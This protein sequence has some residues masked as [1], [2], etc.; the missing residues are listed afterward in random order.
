MSGS[1]NGG[2]E[3]TVVASDEAG[4]VNSY[5]VNMKCPPHPGE[6]GVK[7]AEK[8]RRWKETCKMIMIMKDIKP[9]TAAFLTKMNALGSADYFKTYP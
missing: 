7:G 1:A 2:V 3:A 4:N 8:H 5:G 6:Y 9:K